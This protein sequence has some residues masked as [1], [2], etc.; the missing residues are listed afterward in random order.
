MR[1]FTLVATLAT[2]PSVLIANPSF[3]ASSVKELIALA[4]A[5]PGKLTYGS[6]VPATSTTWWES[7]SSREPE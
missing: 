6:R 1:A 4:K 2:Y 7:Y 3:P 5:T